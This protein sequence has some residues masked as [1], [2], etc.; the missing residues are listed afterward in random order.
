[1]FF[2]VSLFWRSVLCLERCVK[3]FFLSSK[4]YFQFSSYYERTYWNY[5]SKLP[6]LN[7]LVPAKHFILYEGVLLSFRLLVCGQ[8][9]LI[10]DNSPL[11]I[12]C[13]GWYSNRVRAKNITCETHVQESP[14][15]A[16]TN[17]LSAWITMFFNCRKKQ[18]FEFC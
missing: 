13:T 1:M 7:I 8:W 17:H 3:I 2:C 9:N 15:I 10:R 4:K 11:D 12:E 5:Q 6:K 14:C 16:L 18:S